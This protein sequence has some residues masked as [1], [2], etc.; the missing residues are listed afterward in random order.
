MKNASDRMPLLLTGV[1]QCKKTW[2]M[3][4]FGQRY[5]EDVAYFV[6]EENQLFSSLFEYDLNV[7][8]I[9]EELSIIHGKEI[10]VGKTLVIFDEIQACPK[11]I[12]S[13]KYFCEN[14]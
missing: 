13:L 14:K 3:N 9:I 7:D 12:T 11:A 6:F 10:I 8:R 4:T 1:R 2:V 5:F